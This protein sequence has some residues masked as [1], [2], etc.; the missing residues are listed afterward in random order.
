MRDDS[1]TKAVAR[2]YEEFPYP[3][4][5]PNWDKFFEF[6]DPSVYAPLLWPEGAPRKDLR[7][8]FAGCGTIQA[9]RCA[10]R[11][12][13]CHV[14]GID[15][16]EAAI[17]EHWRLKRER[18]LDNL[19]V[20]KLDLRELPNEERTFDL[21][22]STGVLHHLR[23]PEQGLR[24]LAAVLDPRGA[25]SIMLYGSA[26]RVGVYLLQD[27]FRRMG[28]TAD[29]DSA[30]LVRNVL[31]GL[32]KHHYFH[33]YSSNAPDLT[34]DAGLVD[35]LLH[36]QDRAYS[37]PQILQL[38]AGCG[39]QFQGWEDNH[40][41]FPEG[42]IRSGTPLWDRLKLIPAHEQWAVVENVT[43]SLGRHSF[44]A[45]RAERGYREV[46]FSESRWLNYI[47]KQALG[48]NVIERDSA[49]S[50]PRR[51]KRARFEF[52]MDRSEAFLFSACDGRRT[53]SQILDRAEFAGC[54][55][56]A[57]E[58]FGRSFFERMWK[59]G[60]LWMLTATQ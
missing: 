22:F 1:V 42:V 60:H 44:M 2:Q 15:L 28:L 43:L 19:E 48:L 50:L 51:C 7:I 40:L 20:R 10:L 18:G 52:S 45:C 53:I 30:G 31:N 35:T 55:I 38:V 3:P 34:S 47:P 54:S 11:N 36:A 57:R 6:G 41:Y 21:I 59:L 24:A 32:P 46:D 4:A 27:A 13:N 37:V 9:A 14:F 23:Q 17:A 49:G 5:D 8:L 58:E 29:Q 16:S 12:P 56:T 26:P 39:L 33:W 25:M